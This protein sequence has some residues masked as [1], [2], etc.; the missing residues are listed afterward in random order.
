M[1]IEHTFDEIR[2]DH[3]FNISREPV[4]Y[5]D[6]FPLPVRKCAA[7][8]KMRRQKILHR[9]LTENKTIN[10]SVVEGDPAAYWRNGRPGHRA[11][12]GFHNQDVPAYMM[13]MQA[14][15]ILNFPFMQHVR[16]HYK[17]LPG[18]RIQRAIITAILNINALFCPK[19]VVLGH[20]TSPEI[21]LTT[22]A[23]ASDMGRFDL[24]KV[25]GPGYPVY[26]AE[27]TRRIPA[28]VAAN[29]DA[30]IHAGTEKIKT[31]A[32]FLVWGKKRRFMGAYPV[33]EV[34]EN[35]LSPDSPWVSQDQLARKE[36]C[37]QILKDAKDALKVN[38][39]QPI[40][41]IDFGGGVG[42]LSEKLLKRIYAM[43]DSEAET[44]EL[45]K[46]RVRVIVREASGEQICGGRVR[47]KKMGIGRNGSGIDLTGIDGNICFLKNDITLPMESPN[48]AKTEGKTAL[49][50]LG[51][52]WPDFNLENSLVI[53]MSAY[54]L[55]AIPS[56]LMEKAAKEI[57]R[58]CTK[59]Y[60]VDFSSPSWRLKA[61]LKDTGEWGNAYLRAVH[62]KTD[63][64]VDAMLHPHVKYLALSPGLASQY[65]SWPGADGHNSG[66]TI[67]K[68][69][70]LLPPNILTIAEKM[71]QLHE[72]DVYYKSKVRLY[73]LLYLGHTIK[74]NVALACVPGWV[75]DYLLVE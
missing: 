1:S 41:I 69:G 56:G 15:A 39:E 34:P 16:Q 30:L 67:R 10:Q 3:D 59:F 24:Y 62:G 35:H 58:Q 2:N 51:S 29:M 37:H 73:T 75:A 48:Q 36:I 72:K 14:E 13:S 33:I 49:E 71:R 60:A 9:K 52:K 54:V 53:G 50:T 12:S 7:Y 43:P 28:Y 27:M 65:A 68:D 25:L 47:F 55:G 66:Y 63:G 57:S 74:G 26:H 19:R 38:S 61:F 40:Y 21:R 23:F 45:L 4:R 31:P 22:T 8:L 42:N 6:V 32:E 20:S 64:G 5:S 44:R 18:Y 46:K 17:G 70:T 11:L